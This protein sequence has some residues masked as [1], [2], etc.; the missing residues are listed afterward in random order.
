MSFYLPEDLAEIA[1]KTYMTHPKSSCPAGQQMQGE[2]VL[3]VYFSSS[4]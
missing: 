3:G 1:C 4:Q 2:V